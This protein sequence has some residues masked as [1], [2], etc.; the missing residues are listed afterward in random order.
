MRSVDEDAQDAVADAIINDML[1]EYKCDSAEFD[2]HKT[3]MRKYLKL[4]AF[5]SI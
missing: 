5:E 1:M 2:K 4:F 3:R